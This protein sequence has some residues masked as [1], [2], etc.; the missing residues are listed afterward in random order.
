MINTFMFA[1]HA[2]LA[3]T[4][5][6]EEA[7]PDQKITANEVIERMK[8]NVSCDWSN[9]TVDT[10]KSGD[11][12]QEISG[13]AC[14]FMATV[15]VLQKA[16]AEG[17]NLV[18]THE[19]TYYNHFDN[20]DLLEN[21]AVYSA[22]QKI[23][24]DNDLVIFRFHDHWH[25]TSPDGIYVGM[26]EKLGWTEYMEDESYRLF[27]LPD[28]TLTDLT[29]KLEKIFPEAILRVIGDPELQVKHAAFSAGS[30]GS[31][32]HLRLLQR[33][34]V[35]LL[36]FGE[37]NEWETIEYVRDASQAGLPKACIILGHAVSE[38]A[39]MG[40]FTSWLS[41]FV[42]E[43]PVRYIPAGDPFHQ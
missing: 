15:E 3:I 9:E 16:A 21:D 23:I 22:K 19:P 36:V 10:F 13:I 11:P 30:P 18:I 40:Y 20:K 37:A 35:N 34:E 8:E 31:A 4:L 33:E 43:V 39:G 14:T 27:N 12:S 26:V 5:A 42:D 1:L 7:D 25:R 41:E 6:P 24:D 38:E 17:C 28:Q 29:R 2:T 32:A